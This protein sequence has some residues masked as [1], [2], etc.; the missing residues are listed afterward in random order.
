MLSAVTGPWYPI[1]RRVRVKSASSCGLIGAGVGREGRV[2]GAVL[3][4]GTGGIVAG[5]AEGAG[6]AGRPVGVGG[7]YGPR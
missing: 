4:W 7:R 6:S 2:G 3:D 1:P 5:P